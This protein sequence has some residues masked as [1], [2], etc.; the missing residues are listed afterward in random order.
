MVNTVSLD[1]GN[2][3]E[4][5]FDVTAADGYYGFTTEKAY[6]RYTIPADGDYYI[7]VQPINNS[8]SVLMKHGVLRRQIPQEIRQIC[9]LVK[10]MRL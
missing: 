10:R 5:P 8:I 1:G 4:K 6:V 9:I 3:E 2:T 7:A